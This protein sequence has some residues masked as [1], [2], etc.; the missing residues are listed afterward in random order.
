VILVLVGIRP[1]ASSVTRQV[2]EAV[3]DA[4]EIEVEFDSK[5]TTEAGVILARAG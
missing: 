5:I 4:R 1:A 3:S 2:V